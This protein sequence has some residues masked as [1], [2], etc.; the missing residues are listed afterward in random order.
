MDV[1]TVGK[2][3]RALFIDDIVD[4]TIL[5]VEIRAVWN[6]AIQFGATKNEG[7]VTHH[8]VYFDAGRARCCVG[9]QTSILENFE[10][11]HGRGVIMIITAL[12]RMTKVRVKGEEFIFNI[13]ARRG[14]GLK[15]A[16]LLSATPWVPIPY[17]SGWYPHRHQPVSH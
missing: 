17:S 12:C 11:T 16:T 5:A 2:V 4:L 3:N 8:A 13:I 14:S 1:V 6:V 9:D 15:S 10:R 7:A